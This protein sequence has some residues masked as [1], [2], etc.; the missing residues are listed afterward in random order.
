MHAIPGIINDIPA[1]NDIIHSFKQCNIK[2]C[3]DDF[4]VYRMSI[5]KITTP[6]KNILLIPAS[7]TPR[8]QLIATPKNLNG[9]SFDG[10][11]PESFMADYDGVNHNCF[12]N[13]D[14]LK[15]S[16]RGFSPRADASSNDMLLVGNDSLPSPHFIDSKTTRSSK[17]KSAG[18]T[19]SDWPILDTST[20][21][22]SS[23]SSSSSSNNNNSKSNADAVSGTRSTRSG[24]IT[25]RSQQSTTDDAVEAAIMVALQAINKPGTADDVL[26]YLLNNEEN[27]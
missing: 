2:L 12:D 25:S 13:L 6:K 15:F 16:P 14:F 23:S 3:S 1:A 4:K 8:G 21:N 27:I 9:D 10:W 7:S 18:K 24:G 22:N 5:N 17:Q 19:F 26:K 11:F 20:N